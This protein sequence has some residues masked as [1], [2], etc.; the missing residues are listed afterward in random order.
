M[1]KWVIGKYIRLSDADRDLMKKE[2]K[3]ESESVSHQKA[4]IQNFVNEKDELKD[5]EQYEFFDDGFS[6]TNFDR[7]SFEK[8]IEQIKKGKINCVIVKDFSRFGRDYIELGDYLERIFPFMGVRFISINDHY[9]SLDYKGT[10]GGLDVVMKNI[11]YDYYSKDL[12]VKV[13]TAKRAKMKRGLY[14]GGHVPYGYRRCKDDKHRIE[15]DPEAAE[16]VRE[17]YDAALDGMRTVDIAEQLNDKGYETPSA[18]Y[19]RMHP[20]TKKFANASKLSCWNI[21]SVNS[22]LQNKVYYGAVVGHKREAIAP[23]STHTVSVPEDEQIMVEN[24][25]PAIVSKEVFLE[26]QK[27]FRKQ[28][29]QKDDRRYKKERPLVGKTICGTCGRSMNFRAYVAYGREYSYILC[30][31][32]KHQKAGQCCRKYCREADVNEMVWQSIRNLMD[33]AENAAKNVK[34]KADKAQGENLKLAKKLSKLQTDKEKCETERFSN[35]DRFMAG[36]LKKDDYQRIRAEL[37]RKA[38]LL[39]KQIAEV[40][41]K[42]HE[43]EAAA[44]DGV[45]DALNTMKRYSGADKLTREIADAFLD[46][47]LIYDPRHIEIRWKFSDEVIKFIEG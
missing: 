29:P 26:V 22:I 41:A 46:K 38:E 45:Q 10:T 35:V 20:G 37:T 34:K 25:H 32:A 42:L 9:D 15:I 5:C 23:C 18:Y 19:R 43:S 1:S 21:Y 31:H 24:C 17:I 4:L 6:G 39:D 36:E 13:M 3:T 12:S 8:P 14:I 33:L 16:V 2:G 7:P 11:V 27:R 47:I 40:S 28:N 44:D 30:P